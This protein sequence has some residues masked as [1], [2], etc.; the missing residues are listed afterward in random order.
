LLKSRTF[1]A[2]FCT[3]FDEIFFSFCI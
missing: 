2:I 1:S 3:E